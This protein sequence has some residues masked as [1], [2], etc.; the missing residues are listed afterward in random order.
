[1]E[2]LSKISKEF[3][4]QLSKEKLQTLNE[5]NVKSEKAMQTILKTYPSMYIKSQLKDGHIQITE[6]SYTEKYLAE[7]GYTIDDFTTV[8]FREGIPL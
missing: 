5:I 4:G 2:I 3:Q 8:M 7:M 1:M 6:I